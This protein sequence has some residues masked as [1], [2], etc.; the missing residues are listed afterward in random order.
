MAMRLELAS[1]P[2]KTV[3]F[4][5]QTRYA[6]GVLE[7]DKA[8]L[9]GLVTKDERIISADLDV[10]IPGEQ[11]RI[12]HIG[13][14]VEPRIKVSGPGCVF[15][16]I[17]GPVDTVGQGRTNRLAG[18][19]LVHS[20]QYEPTELT[21]TASQRLGVVDMW[22]PGAQITPLG[23]TINVV[24][25]TQLVGGITELEAHSAIQLAECRLAHRLAETTQ[26]LEPESVE[27][28]ELNKVDASL[29]RV[30]YIL[31]WVTEWHT[32][33]SRLAYYGLH[34]KESLP[35]LVHPNEFLD[36][37]LTTDARKGNS[38]QPLTWG[39]M[40]QPVVL[41]LLREHGKR[42]NF[43]GVILQRTRFESEFGKRVTAT[44]T[45]QLAS[46]LEA[47]GAIIT[48]TSPSGN[49]L[50]DA[51]FT[52]EACEK[53]GIKTVFLTPEAGGSDGTGPAL[54]F[55]VPEATRMISTG[56][57]NMEPRLP[58]PT[59]VIGCKK[60]ELAVLRPGDPPISPWGELKFD[61]G[62][63]IAESVDWFG[64][65]YATCALY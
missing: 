43:L 18:L 59:K 34:V 38:T 23:S 45:S 35:T 60:G 13:D 64:D 58:A 12:V 54:H 48:R 47:D 25:V 11:T 31:G 17:L 24:L 6:D 8:E 39:L 29:P 21:G 5:R 55:Y 16:G 61:T 10:A 28:F 63:D 40:N 19:T 56:N 52:V 62:T 57:I 15:P 7:L 65:W 46:L 20:S 14:V 9:L 4:D 2:V 33:H 26:N 3:R 1:F 36:G 44:C 53:K 51:M 32:P 41:A 37:A 30:V 50:M 42:V 49:N 22:G 27:I